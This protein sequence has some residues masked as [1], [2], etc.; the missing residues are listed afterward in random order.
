MPDLGGITF[1]LCL[2]VV[3]EEKFIHLAHSDL[4]T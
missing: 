3:D 1:N 2:I 4:I